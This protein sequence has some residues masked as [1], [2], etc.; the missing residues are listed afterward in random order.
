MQNNLA[1]A[2]KYL[3][4]LNYNEREALFELKGKINEIYPGSKFILYGSKARGDYN[5]NSDIDLLIVINDKHNIDKD[6]SFEELE[7]LYFLA[8]DKKIKDEILSIV[9]DVELKHDVFIDCQVENKNYL[10]TRI[11]GI[12]PWYENVKRDGMEL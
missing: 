4:Y 7:K 5:L 3:D 12:M 6:I 1:A 2:P 8:V 9:V 11:A 10:N